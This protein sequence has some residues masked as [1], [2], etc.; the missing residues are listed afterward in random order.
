MHNL[1]C[2]LSVL[3]QYVTIFARYRRL[4]VG[5]T[6]HKEA[7]IPQPWRLQALLPKGCKGGSFLRMDLHRHSTIGDIRYIASSFLSS[8]YRTRE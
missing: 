3:C 7:R 1:R 5:G 6:G 2:N 4:P 8:F